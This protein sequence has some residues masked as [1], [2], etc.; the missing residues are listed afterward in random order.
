LNATITINATISSND[1]RSLDQKL[2]KKQVVLPST[3]PTQSNTTVTFNGTITINATIESNARFS[4][5]KDAVKKRQLISKRAADNVVENTHAKRGFNDIG[6]VESVEKTA[7][8]LK[9]G[10]DSLVFHLLHPYEPPVGQNNGFVAETGENLIGQ[11]KTKRNDDGIKSVVEETEKKALEILQ[12]LKI[13]RGNIHLGSVIE[14][15]EGKATE[16]VESLKNKRVAA[17]RL[18]PR[19]G[20]P[21]GPGLSELVAIAESILRKYGITKAY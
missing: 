16:I 14:E 7:G 3:L 13:K 12:G 10:L 17:N 6:I 21:V 18:Q 20:G 11:S 2:V 5:E 19:G 15:V 1:R 4:S 8:S 9:S